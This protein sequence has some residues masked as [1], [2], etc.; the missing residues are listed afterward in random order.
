MRPQVPVPAT[1]LATAPALPADPIVG[2]QIGAGPLA[3]DVDKLL[4]TLRDHGLNSLFIFAFG[5]EARFIPMNGGNFRGGNYAIP[6]M[7]YYKDANLTYDDM[8]APGIPG[9][10]HTRAC[11]EGFQKAWIQDLCD[12]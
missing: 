6:H 5:H 3:G 11:D 10:R 7:E 12:C 1:P 4:D 8:R 9:H 2:I